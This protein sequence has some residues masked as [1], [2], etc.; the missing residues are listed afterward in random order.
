M[1]WSSIE[2][3]AL[4]L[5]WPLLAAIA[6]PFAIKR[7]DKLIIAIGDARSLLDDLPK[8]VEAGN[9]MQ[10]FKSQIAEIISTQEELRRNQSELI[11]LQKYSQEQQELRERQREIEE[12]P[13]EELTEQLG[14]DLEGSNSADNA[15]NSP[16][17][18]LAAEWELV[19][20]SMSRAFARLGL[21]QPDLRKV[22]FEARRLSDGRRRN[23]LD[24]RTVENIT[25]L[26]AVYKGFLR[27]ARRDELTDAV[28]AN[29]TAEAAAVRAALD[30]L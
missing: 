13:L 2:R 1:I 22:A 15:D 4:G 26:Q 23:P 5:A 16:M 17:A 7:I 21:G 19:K 28:L 27:S 11:A 20:T 12:Q 24:A 6:L 18:R 3:L 29:F 30:G 8:F 10:S 25:A 9:I 14:N